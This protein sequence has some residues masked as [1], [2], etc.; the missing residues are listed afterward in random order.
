VNSTSESCLLRQLRLGARSRISAETSNLSEIL[1]YL[2]DWERAREYAER[3]AELARSE[4][5][6]LTPT[7]FQYAN[8][9]RRLG[10]IRTAMGDWEEAVSSLEESVALAERIPFPEAVRSGQGVLAELE[11][12]QGKPG[13]ALVRLEPLVERSDPEELGTVRLLPCLAWAYLE[14][15]NDARAEEVVLDG[16]DRARAQGHRLALVESL[17]VRGMVLVRRHRRDEAERAFEEAVSV[18]RS[19]RYPYAEARTL[20][21]WGLMHVGGP[22][23]ERGRDR[24]EEAA[25]IFRELG[26][27]PYSD[28]AQKAMSGPTP[29]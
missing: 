6:G 3:A 1:F 5:S 15:G 17:R 12:L 11:L 20:Y 25:E 7:Y 19:S 14:V 27:R 9:F 21:E 23:P 10:M 24:L 2:G 28:L 18:A 29:G 22:D 26:S 8:V 13:A 4:S 16:I